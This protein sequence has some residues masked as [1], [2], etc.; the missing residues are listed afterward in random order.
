MSESRDDRR[1]FENL[2]RAKIE[3][4]WKTYFIWLV[5]VA[6]AALA[7]WFLYSNIV[8]GGPT[9]HLYFDNAAG[10]Q[11][12]KSELKYRG[13]DL[14]EVKELKLTKDSKKVE[15]TVALG[16]SA[17]GVAREGSRFWIVKPEVGVQ[18]IRGL[19]TIVSGDYIT[20]E[21][22]NGKPQFQFEGLA[23]APVIEP[24]GMRR[25]I[26]LAEKTGALKPQTPVFYRGIQVGEVFSVDLGDA[27]QAVH[28]VVDIRKR[29]APLVRMNSKF[30]NA[31]GIHANISLSGLNIG[32][33]SLETLI[34]GGIDFATPDLSEKEAPSQTNFRLYDKPEV[35]WLAWSPPIELGQKNSTA[36]SPTNAFK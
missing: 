17:A 11:K 36:N 24:A 35:A 3:R 29:Y 6:A 14:G 21:P 23:D 10:L 25:I 32:A 31:G 8:K 9:I 34:S 33:Q 5:P 22:G 30:W 28:L 12:G 1:S 2:P 27:S 18:E 16:R 19:R 13:A 15:V 4:N 20:V 26:L 7:A